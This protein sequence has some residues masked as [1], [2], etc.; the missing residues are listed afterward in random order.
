MT[1]ESGG[2][3]ERG[4]FLELFDRLVH[5]GYQTI[6]PV[7]RDGAIVYAEVSGP[8]D[9]PRGLRD[10]QSPGSYRLEAEGSGRFFSWANGP[11]P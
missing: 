7:V 2:F 9:L 3:L 1:D 4:R 10:L 6:A 5:R 11:R 8:E